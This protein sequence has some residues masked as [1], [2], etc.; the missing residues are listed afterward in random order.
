MLIWSAVNKKPTGIYL[1]NRTNKDYSC[2]RTFFVC[3]IK[4]D[5]NSWQWR[6]LEQPGL[7]KSVSKGH[8]HERTLHDLILSNNW[9]C[10]INHFTVNSCTFFPFASNVAMYLLQAVEEIGKIVSFWFHLWRVYQTL[11]ILYI[12]SI[13]VSFFFLHSPCIMSKN[14]C[15]YLIVWKC[16]SK[17]LI[18]VQ[19][20]TG[21]L[22]T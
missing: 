3:V 13:F 5:L 15:L 7:I 4:E 12:F 14:L 21:I 6:L 16:S 17:H 11:A 10:Q 2:A 18:C 19:G 1:K 22:G 9:T 20:E 8:W